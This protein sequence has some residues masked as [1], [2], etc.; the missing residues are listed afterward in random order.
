[1]SQIYYRQ[2]VEQ[3]R[4]EHEMLTGIRFEWIILLRPDTTYTDALPELDKLDSNKIHIVPWQPWGGINDRFG[5]FPRAFTSVYFN[6]YQ[7]LCFKGLAKALPLVQNIEVSALPRLSIGYDVAQHTP[8][9]TWRT[10]AGYCRVQPSVCTQYA[11]GAP[12]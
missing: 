2:R 11:R 8:H 7:D 1:M 10:E 5:I 4:L 6:L 3:L 9:A 12:E